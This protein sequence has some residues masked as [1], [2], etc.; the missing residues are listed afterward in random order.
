MRVA[1]DRLAIRDKWYKDIPNSIGDKGIAGSADVKTTVAS[2]TAKYQNK[3]SGAN[4]TAKG[5]APKKECP[6]PEI[7][8]CVNELDDDGDDLADATACAIE[9]EELCE[10]PSPP[11]EGPADPPGE[12]DI[13]EPM[14]ESDGE[15]GDGESGGG[16]PGPRTINFLR[17]F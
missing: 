11:T 9:L 15:G 1:F 2:Y 12:Y 16:E 13:Y 7:K 5:E 14:H 8:C 10:E 4:Y 6:V 3:S 17:L